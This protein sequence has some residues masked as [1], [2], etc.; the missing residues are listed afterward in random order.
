MSKNRKLSRRERH[1]AD[2]YATEINPV[3]Y[4]RRERAIKWQPVKDALE[5]AGIVLCAAM[6]GVA[7]WAFLAMTH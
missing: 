5:A 2:V 3:E 1:I 6:V 4:L 7:A